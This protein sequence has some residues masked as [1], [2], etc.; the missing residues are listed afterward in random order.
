MFSLKVL[1]GLSLDTDNGTLLPGARQKRRLG[2]LA[3][4]AIAGLRGTSRERV[5]AYLYPES[6]SERARHALD[7]LLYATRQALRSEPFIMAGGEVRLAECIVQSDVGLF[8]E[9]I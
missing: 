2:L 6:S 1:G 9:A 5:Q 8:A 3:I 7:Q 4:L